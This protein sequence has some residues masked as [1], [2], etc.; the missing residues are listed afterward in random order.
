MIT[1]LH[2]ID[3]KNIGDLYS[4]P[5]K[6]F[7]FPG[8][9]C[10]ATDIRSFT[11]E[12]L[13]DN[14]L[15]VGGGGLIFNRFLPEFQTIAAAFTKGK[16]IL[17]GA[18]YQIYG[19]NPSR[20]PKDFDFSPY[21]SGFDLVGLRDKGTA[22]EWVPCPSCMHPAFDKDRTPEHEFVV[23]SHK[24]F[25][26]NIPGLPRLSNKESNFEKVL[27]FLGSGET[28]LTSSF[29]GAYWG[30]LLGRR[31]L[32]FPFSSKFFTLQHSPAFY[33]VE[34]WT[35]AKFKFALFGKVLHTSNY[36]NEKFSCVTQ[37]WIQHA[38]KSPIYPDLVEE[39]R[40]KN[41]A[42]YHQVMNVLA[43]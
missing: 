14:H 12:D 5:L 19:C 42:F 22:Y 1:N 13:Q 9:A 7:D 25:Q 39:C 11:R 31:V 37:N 26:I 3:P 34:K 36:D 30:T 2:V 8:Y 24:K 23:F 15:I 38:L 40:A 32:A 17:W 41:R 27:D 20:W 18:G 35:Q 29:H 16:R 6:Y 10:K 4:S 21:L 43:D 33:P 28:I